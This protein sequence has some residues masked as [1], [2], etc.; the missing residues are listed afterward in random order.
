M[1]WL[2]PEWGADFSDGVKVG[3][4]RWLRR[5]AHPIGGAGLCEQYSASALA[6]QRRQLCF[7]SFCFL[8]FIIFFFA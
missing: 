5:S 7:W 8:L 2:V 1:P 3:L 4:E 6:P